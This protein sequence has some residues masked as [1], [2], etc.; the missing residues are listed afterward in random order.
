M[1][2]FLRFFNVPPHW[3]Q[4]S[5]SNGMTAPQRLHAFSYPT[6]LSGATIVFSIFFSGSIYSVSSGRNPTPPPTMAPTNNPGRSVRVMFD[7]SI[8]SV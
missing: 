4:K 5:E 1:A 3:L 7:T 2:S 6:T 8:H